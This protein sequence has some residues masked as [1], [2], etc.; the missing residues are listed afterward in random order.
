M[1]ESAARI[2]IDQLYQ[3]FSAARC[4]GESGQSIVVLRT[5]HTL[6]L[7][8]PYPIPH[9]QVILR[10]HSSKEEVISAFDVDC[11]GV[12]FDGQKVFVTKRCI[13]ALNSHCNVAMPERRSWTYE[14]RLLK[15]VKRGYS[16]AVPGLRSS[17]VQLKK[18]FKKT[19]YRS[20]LDK[21]DPRFVPYGNK[22][23][24]EKIDLGWEWKFGEDHYGGYYG[25]SNE[26]EDMPSMVRIKS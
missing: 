26:D 23:A 8:C 17:E 24:Y 11:C 7:V 19:C 22:K 10:L 20:Q 25:Q 4:I 2:K 12:M 21:E 3:K 5:V 16:I 14:S 6:T 18:P 13:R 9:T 15:Y 1:T